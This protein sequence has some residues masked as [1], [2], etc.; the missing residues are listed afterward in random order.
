MLAVS[1]RLSASFVGATH[2]Q[3]KNLRKLRFQCLCLQPLVNWA[4]A[5]MPA[6]SRLAGRVWG[7]AFALNQGRPK[8][9]PSFIFSVPFHAR[10]TPLHSASCVAF[11]SCG[12]G[13]IA[14]TPP[15]RSSQK[16]NSASSIFFLLRC[17][18]V[19]DCPRNIQL[20]TVSPV[21]I[22]KKNKESRR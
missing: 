2:P 14:A 11:P 13:S 6:P 1:T 5:A 3:H 22:P 21:H 8:K 17:L 18:G 10:S 4:V 19:F 15:L 12:G 16:E 20:Q 9:G 7:R